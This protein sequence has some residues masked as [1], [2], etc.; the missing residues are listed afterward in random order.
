MLNGSKVV[1]G[2]V[3]GGRRAVRVPESRKVLCLGTVNGVQ[4]NVFF[5]SF[6]RTSAK[7]PRSASCRDILDQSVDEVSSHHAL[8]SS[9]RGGG[10]MPLVYAPSSA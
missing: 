3:T 10:G 4:E 5:R 6:F 2:P 7:H 8:A 9:D 1:C